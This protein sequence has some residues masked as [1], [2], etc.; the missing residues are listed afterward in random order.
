MKSF[1]TVLG[2][3]KYDLVEEVPNSFGFAIGKT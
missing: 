1:G 2:N 3:K